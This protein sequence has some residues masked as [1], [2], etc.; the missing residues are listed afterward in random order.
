MAKHTPGPWLICGDDNL[1]VYALHDNGYGYWADG[2]RE[3]V[4]RFYARI[5]DCHHQGGSLPEA[6]ANA[7]LIAAAPDLLEA[8][9]ECT[10]QLWL[11]AK[12]P[13]SNP[14]VLQGHAAIAKAT[15]LEREK[16]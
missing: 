6:Q 14:W 3:M 11:L 12:D 13:K 9:K 10:E 5:E 4:N 2:K 15:G 16:I 8:L 7:L 1:S